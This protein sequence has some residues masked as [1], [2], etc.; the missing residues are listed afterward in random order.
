MADGGAILR[1]ARHLRQW[2]DSTSSATTSTNPIEALRCGSSHGEAAVSSSHMHGGM[3]AHNV[4]G[5]ACHSDETVVGG[6]SPSLVMVLGFKA[7]RKH[8]LEGDNGV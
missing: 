5:G 8:T 2:Q 6:G 1:Q 7:M 4:R 3:V